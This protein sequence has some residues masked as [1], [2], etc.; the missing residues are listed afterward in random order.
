MKQQVFPLSLIGRPNVQS[1]QLLMAELFGAHKLTRPSS[2]HG[3]V[4][5]QLH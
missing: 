3:R 5:G 1:Q 4:C 2:V